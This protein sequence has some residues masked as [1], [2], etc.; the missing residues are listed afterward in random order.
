MNEGL[1]ASAMRTPYYQLPISISIKSINHKMLREMHCS[2]C[3]M[4]FVSITDKIVRV[5]D[6]TIPIE[7]L[8]PEKPGIIE[9]HCPRARCKQIYQLEF[10]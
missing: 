3:G 4:P 5:S 10:A 9:S 2:E 7:R 1:T 8:L 6:S